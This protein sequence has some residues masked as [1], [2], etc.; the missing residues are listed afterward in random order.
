ME[1][2][3][4]ANRPNVQGSEETEIDLLKLLFN[5]LEHLPVIIV[6]T[7]V[8]LIGGFGY[9]KLAMP[10]MYT[11]RTS[12]YVRNSD[13]AERESVS[14]ADLATSRNL[15]NTYIVI[16]EN[17]VVI[18]RVGDE[19]IKHEQAAPNLGKCFHLNSDGSIRT[20]ELKRAIT[21][22]SASNTEVLV[23]SAT[24]QDPIVSAAI[25]DIY[26][27]IAPEYLIRIVGAGSVEAIGAA[28]IPS[29]PS[30]PNVMKNTMIAAMIGFVLVCG[31]YTL[32]FLLDRSIKE[33]EDIKH[34]GLPFLGDIPEINTASGKKNKKGTDIQDFAATTLLS[35]DIP[36]S[37]TE[38]Y[39]AIRTNIMFSLAVR[40]KKIIAV[41][42]PNQAEGKSSSAAN[43]ALTLA[44]TEA[45]VLLIDADLRKPTVHMRF[46]LENDKGLSEVLG[47][48]CKFDS[49]VH[50][51]VAKHLDIL[52]CGTC[53]PNPSEL[54]TSSI[55]KALLHGLEQRY[56]YIVIDTPPVNV[57]TDAL[58]LAPYIGGLVLVCKYN[59][60]TTDEF[61][62]AV[63]Q[64]NFTNADI[65]GVM[66][67]QVER[68]GV[69]Y[70][71]YGK[72]GRYGKY[73]KYG[74]YGRY[75]RY[76]GKYG[77]GSGYGYGYGYGYGQ[78][79]S[80]NPFAEGTAAAAETDGN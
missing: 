12:M 51:D 57:V 16:L 55:M 38:S 67:T 4:T 45:K 60:T 9:T 24:T 64:I 53:P 29:S 17:N 48:M 62:A 40:E 1:P 79:G 68:G 28:D 7:L 42:S 69:G 49:A 43:I 26:A 70:G 74:K 27:Q 47:R 78:Q 21:M 31:I 8:F 18:R 13:N 14:N 44:Q 80:D 58:G 23:V 36:F 34:Y 61:A 22:A 56:D 25:C 50:K 2:N 35:K 73:G 33:E 20:S 76:G 39:K 37:V 65:L 52:T 46:S 32:I 11:A 54:L 63:Q 3:S 15:V 5:L 75:K 6:V 66:I 59:S 71:K 41:T 72:Y 10:L 77:Y 30:S 19:L